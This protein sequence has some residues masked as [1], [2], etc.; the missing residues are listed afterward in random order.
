[1]VLPKLR[2]WL[3]ELGI[4]LLA[5][6]FAIRELGTFPAAWA[7]DS[8]FMI[9]ARNVAEGDGYALRILDHVW[10]YPYILGVGPTLILPSALAIKFLGFSVEAARLPQMGF[11]LATA[12]IF[13]VLAD[14]TAGRTSARWSTLLL[15]TFSAFVNT[16][17]PLLGEIPGF[18]F[19]LLGL[20]V[21]QRGE[22]TAWHAVIAGIA[23]GLAVLT[24]LT[25]GLIYPALGIAGLAALFRKDWREFSLLFLMGLAALAVSLPWRLLEASVEGG[26]SKDFLFLWGQSEDAVA[27]PFA[28]LLGNPHILLR[29]PFLSF[30]VFLVLG[31]LG[32]RERWRA[33]L[34]HF[35][36]ITSSLIVLFTLY[37]L[38]SFGW[39]R[40]L[41]PAHLL[42]L[43]FVPIGA[44]K[45]FTRCPAMLFLATVAALQCFWQLGHLGASGSTE[46]AEAATV[47]QRDLKD[48]D[49]IIRQAEVFTRLPKNPRW[50]FLTSPKLSE[51]L[52]ATY[53]EKTPAQKCTLTLRKFSEEERAEFKY[54]IV[55]LAGRYALLLPPASCGLR[56]TT[57]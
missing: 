36:L 13:Y 9:V 49:L 3:P 25:Y 22:K 1:M 31:A 4:G 35:S 12:L 21:L 57:H 56:G 39:Y 34:E 8:L 40:H 5:L 2:W 27:A 55:P 28:H 42:L 18:F 53:T 19:L 47:I 46:A 6:F 20:F 16:G 50:L 52:P 37:F 48:R 33:P 45:L 7:D 30:V 10:P 41:L 54:Q 51:R 26:L 14:R 43:L 38:S 24:K 29:L 17:K 23:F 32:L 44:E 15:V 11:L